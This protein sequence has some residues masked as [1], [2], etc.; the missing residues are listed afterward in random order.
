MGSDIILNSASKLKVFF[1]DRNDW[2]IEYYQNYFETISQALRVNA[3]HH[4]NVT[5]FLLSHTQIRRQQLQ[6]KWWD[7]YIHDCKL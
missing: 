7:F 5:S 1:D 6:N 4:M 3:G 2:S